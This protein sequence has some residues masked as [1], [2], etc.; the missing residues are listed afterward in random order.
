MKPNNPGWGQ[1][2]LHTALLA[3]VF[4]MVIIVGCQLCE[5]QDAIY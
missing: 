5:P 1:I 3:I 4:V 2:F